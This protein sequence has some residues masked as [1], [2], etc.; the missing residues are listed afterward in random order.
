MVLFNVL[1][2]YYPFQRLHNGKKGNTIMAKRCTKCGNFM[3]EDERF[4][5]NCGENSQLPPDAVMPAVNP[6]EQPQQN[7]GY[8]QQQYNGYNQQQYNAAPQYAAPQP[9]PQEEMSVKQWVGTIV[10]TTFFGLISLIFLFIWGFG[11]GPESRKRYCKAMLITMLIAMGVGMILSMLFFTVFAAA[12][13]DKIP[14][15]IKEFENIKVVMTSILPV[16]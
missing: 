4:C 15:I 10:V 12:F 7:Y 9:A 6:S 1:A 3:M 2:D 8:A 14:E 5:P 13:G 11:E 16:L